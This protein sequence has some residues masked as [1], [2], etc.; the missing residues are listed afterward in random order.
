MPEPSSHPAPPAYP[1]R[2]ALFATCLGLALL[3]RV[4]EAVARLLAGLGVEMCSPPDQVCCG[5]SLMK[6]GQ[7]RQAAQ[8]G[9]A[10]VRAFRDAPLVVSPSGSCVAHVRHHLPGLLAHRPT[11]A[12]QASALAART[13][14]LSEFLTK[15]LDAPAEL[16]RRGAAAPAEPWAYHPSCGL[17]RAL[18][19]DEAPYRLL[20]ALA[21]PPR[22][23][24]EE[25]ER[26]CGFGGPFSVSHPELS[27]GMLTQKL[28]S[29]AK[30][31]ARTLVVGDLG[32]LLHLG[33]GVRERG[34]GLRVIHLAELLAE[35]LE[36]AQVQARKA[37]P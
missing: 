19:E 4:G 35:A 24:L 7:P 3:P 13:F 15:V 28:D 32:C 36:P 12:A 30:A 11:L 27:A 34:E 23:E 25:P 6:A 18:G 2:A 1:R 21:G 10:W 20:E 26:C 8:V 22:L 16:R 9:A 14:E 17:H 29:A 37:R 5:Q 33:C 31:G